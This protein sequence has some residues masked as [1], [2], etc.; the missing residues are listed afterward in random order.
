MHTPSD[1]LI[2]WR[3]IMK[4]EQAVRVILLFLL[5]FLWGCW[6]SSLNFQVRYAA[7]E[8]L[9]QG[10]PVYFQQNIIGTIKKVSYTPQ[11]DYL[12]SIS[13][14]SD[15]KNAVTTDSKF[16]IEDDRL[17]QQNKAIMVVQER[18]GGTILKGDTIVQGSVRAGFLSEMLT[19]LKRTAEI[20]EQ[21]MRTARHQLEKSL[22]ATSERMDREM[23]GALDNLARQ[24][25]RFN[26]E[27]KKVPEREEIKQL[28][29]SIKKFVD[30]FNKG[31]KDV[32]DHI[33]EDVLPQFRRELDRLRE[34]LH[35]EGREGEIEVIDR[36]IGEMRV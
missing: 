7:I 35:K 28:D 22:L 32:R 8:G 9:T 12:V 36:H 4:K 24:F 2:E 11:G 29:Q 26:V 20:A 27:I 13:I 15:F 18:S 23:T 1:R 16:V 25:Q 5:P 17:G 6:E 21:E 33:R 31:Q 34:R 10:D 30:E 14:K 19:G 3:N